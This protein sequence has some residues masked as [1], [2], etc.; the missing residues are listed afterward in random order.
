M[1]LELLLINRMNPIPGPLQEQQ[2]FCHLQLPSLN[3]SLKKFFFRL[4]VVVAHIINPVGE[5]EGREMDL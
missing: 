3:T 5:S 4:V 2:V 1:E